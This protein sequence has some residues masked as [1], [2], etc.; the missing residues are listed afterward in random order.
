MNT[1]TV[2]QLTITKLHT[3]NP[4]NGNIKWSDNKGNNSELVPSFES[5]SW[6][7]SG[8]GDKSSIKF[9]GVRLQLLSD[10]SIQAGTENW[11]LR[12]DFSHRD[13]RSVTI[14]AIIIV[15]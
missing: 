14:I 7:W 3:I 5:G 8:Y 15:S 10:N 4:G 12:P 13:M 2:K 9:S 1:K 6:W 11:E